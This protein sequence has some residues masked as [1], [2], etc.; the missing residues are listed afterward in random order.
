MRKLDLILESIKDEYMINLLEEGEITE[1]ETLKTKKFLNENISRIRKMLIEEGVLES[2]QDG[3]SSSWGIFLAESQDSEELEEAVHAGDSK[4]E[5]SFT[6]K[7]KENRNEL[8]D[9]ISSFRNYRDTDRQRAK[10]NNILAF[11][12]KMLNDSANEHDNTARVK[13]A[14]G[15]GNYGKAIKKASKTKAPG[16]KG[17]LGKKAPNFESKP[18]AFKSATK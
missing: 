2:I 4:Y 1:L 12:K 5:K 10:S 8:A 9:S 16:I 11:Q 7:N 6:K 3:L 13:S 15:S 18:R 14:A 17:V